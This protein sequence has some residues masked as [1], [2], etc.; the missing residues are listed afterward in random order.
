M[1]ERGKISPWQAMR[2]MISFVL[3]GA[4]LLIPPDLAVTAKQDAWLSLLFAI[5]A[6]LG[7]FLFYINLALKFP[8]KTIIQYSEII[9]GKFLGKIAGLFL[10]WFA[11]HLGSLVVLDFGEFMNTTILHDTPMIVINGVIVLLAVFAVR[12]GL[13]V[14][15]RIN[16]VLLPVVV[17]MVLIL[18]FLA[19]LW[20]RA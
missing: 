6:G 16:D 17:F 9:L 3:G 18:T 8:G 14:F 7:I 10:I 13:E 1:L 4:I 2:L 11:L 20:A 5:L 15:T 12:Q 19:I